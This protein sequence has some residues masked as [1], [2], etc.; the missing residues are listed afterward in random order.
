MWKTILTI[1]QNLFMLA[2]DLEENRTEIKELN[3]KVYRLTNIVQRLS[4]KLDAQAQQ[5]RAEREKLT[6]QLENELLKSGREVK[7]L[8]SKKRGKKQ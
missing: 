1:V 7:L 6:L 4:D 5:E 3:E 2:R 8:P